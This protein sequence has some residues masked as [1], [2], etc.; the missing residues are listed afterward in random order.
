MT[1]NNLLCMIFF[2]HRT[3]ANP[4]HTHHSNSELFLLYGYP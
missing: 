3:D 2:I 4:N 1:S